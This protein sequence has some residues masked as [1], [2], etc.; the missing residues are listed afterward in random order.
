[1]SAVVMQLWPQHQ[2]MVEAG[3]MTLGQAGEIQLLQE[4]TPFGEWI[5]LPDHLQLPARR[6]HLFEMPAENRLP[7]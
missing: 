3:V 5:I 7:L 6:A 1:M 2:Q 4:G